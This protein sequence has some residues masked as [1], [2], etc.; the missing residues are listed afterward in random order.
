MSSTIK[1]TIRS[2]SRFVGMDVR[3]Y[4]Q[5]W[6]HLWSK[7]SRKN[8][9]TFLMARSSSSNLAV[10]YTVSKRSAAFVGSRLFSLCG[11]AC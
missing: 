4:D 1:Q 3:S 2:V 8:N 6:P 5:D 10:G 7:G 11:N 9:F